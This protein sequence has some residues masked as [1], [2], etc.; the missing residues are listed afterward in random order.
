MIRNVPKSTALK[1][2]QF[3]KEL[4]VALPVKQETQAE[5]WSQK[6]VVSRGKLYLIM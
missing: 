5:T 1:L 4:L 2:V 3:K 6:L